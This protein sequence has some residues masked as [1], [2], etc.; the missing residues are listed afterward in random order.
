MPFP[1]LAAGVGLRRQLEDVRVRGVR[2][3]EHENGKQG[4]AHPLIVT[5]FPRACQRRQWL[6]W[7]RAQR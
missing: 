2:H 7:R 4:R 1:E 3:A 5:G 6:A